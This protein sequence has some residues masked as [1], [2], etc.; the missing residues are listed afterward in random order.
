MGESLHLACMLYGEGPV[1]IASHFL[2]PVT[3]S[4]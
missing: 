4:T 2:L 3:L 1:F